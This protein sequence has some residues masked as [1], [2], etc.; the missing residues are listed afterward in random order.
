ME[1]QHQHL[2]KIGDL[3]KLAGVT[4]RTI[5]Y[6]EE[7]GLM[8]PSETS[9][10]GFRLYTENDKRR[11]FYIKRF[12]ELEFPLEDIKALLSSHIPTEDKNRRIAASIALLEEQLKQVESKILELEKVK[13]E[14]KKGKETLSKCCSCQLHPC[15]SD[16]P[17]K[18]SMF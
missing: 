5:R 14:I 15:L 13:Q 2:Y 6:Y 3:A 12:K 9:P 8:V 18:E 10:G 16:C 4:V 1:Q 7:L 11:L 17:S